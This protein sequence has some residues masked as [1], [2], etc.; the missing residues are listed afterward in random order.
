MRI[1]DWSSDVCS[2]D[3]LG[4]DSEADA[5]IAARRRDKRGVDA[6]D[7][8]VD[9]EHRAARIALVD[10]GVGLDIAIVGTAAG[11]AGVQGGD[12]ACRDGAA[13]AEGIADRADPVAHPRLR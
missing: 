3:L 2:S 5:D 10:G 12:D 7:V 8:A 1:S 4:R 9:V 13:K 6:D 11:N